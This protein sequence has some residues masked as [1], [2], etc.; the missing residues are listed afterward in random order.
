MQL[1][2]SFA[3]TES[4]LLHVSWQLQTTSKACI[5]VAQTLNR[6]RSSYNIYSICS[7][8]PKDCLSV[9]SSC[10][11][12]HDF[13]H[14]GTLLRSKK[15]GLVPFKRYRFWESSQINSVF[16]LV[17]SNGMSRLWHWNIRQ[18]RTRKL[19]CRSRTYGLKEQFCCFW[20]LRMTKLQF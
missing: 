2:D 15:A 3:S 4:F 17:D 9:E 14:W 19:A 20:N 18:V 12:R 8:G 16:H 7:Q 11:V 13:Q 5:L 1:L 10:R 6:E